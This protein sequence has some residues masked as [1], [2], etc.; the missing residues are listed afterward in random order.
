MSGVTIDKANFTKRLK[1]LYSSW[2]VKQR[3]VSTYL[4]GRQSAG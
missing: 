2:Q 1:S 3:I 4:Q